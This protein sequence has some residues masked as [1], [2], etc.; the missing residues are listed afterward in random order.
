M[1]AKDIARQTYDYIR[2]TGRISWQAEE[3]INQMGVDAFL[4]AA[5]AKWESAGRPNFING[6]KSVMYEMIYS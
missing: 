4:A 1:N 3:V 2:G 6:M 5:A